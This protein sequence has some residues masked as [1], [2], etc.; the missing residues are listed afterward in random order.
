MVGGKETVF[1]TPFVQGATVTCI[2]EQQYRGPKVLVFKKKR[3]H[4]Y[5][6]MRGHRSEL[7]RLFVSEIATPTGVLKPA[8]GLKAHV[9]DEEHTK[10]VAEKKAT[11]K[12]AAGTSDEV[13]KAAAPK[14]AKKKAAPKKTAAKSAKAKTKKS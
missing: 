9:L 7:T 11:L 4:K 6:K 5:R 1:G 3:R 8:E 14:T 10:K 12:A 2:V 13:T